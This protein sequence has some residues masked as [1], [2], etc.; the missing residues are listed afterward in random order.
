MGELLRG[1]E[2]R[3]SARTAAVPLGSIGCALKSFEPLAT[4]D[5]DYL[6]KATNRGD[7]RLKIVSPDLVVRRI[8]RLDVRPLEKLEPPSI[9]ESAWKFDP[10]TGVIGMQN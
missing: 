4:N 8:A 6:A 9:C 7:K 10:R 3:S 2:N 5:F 1:F